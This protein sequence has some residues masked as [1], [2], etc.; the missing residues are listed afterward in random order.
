MSEFR[1]NAITNRGGDGGPVLLSSVVGG[2]GG[3]G[4]HIALHTG[5]KLIWY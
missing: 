3:G 4:G 5:V 1:V 2:G